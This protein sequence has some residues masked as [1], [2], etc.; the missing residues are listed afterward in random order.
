M[1]NL[2]R[3][4]IIG[5]SLQS[6]KTFTQFYLKDLACDGLEFFSPGFDGGYPA[7]LPLAHI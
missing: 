6:D 5:Q 4:F 1:W 7:D 2:F 3:P